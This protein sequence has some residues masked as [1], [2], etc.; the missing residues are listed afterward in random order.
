MKRYRIFKIE[1]VR[2]TNTL[3]ERIKITDLWWKESV[4]INYGSD[5]SSYR[6]QHALNFLT[7]KGIEVFADA[8]TQTEEDYFLTPDFKQRIK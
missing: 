6:K 4:V 5:E 8:P 1:T 7:K 3:P 2:Q